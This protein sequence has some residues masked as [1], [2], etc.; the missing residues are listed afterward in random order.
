M[1]PAG[2]PTEERKQCVYECGQNNSEI[3]T[4]LEKNQSEELTFT[5]CSAWGSILGHRLAVFQMSKLP[6]PPPP[7]HHHHHHPSQKSPDP[8]LWGSSSHKS[9]R[10]MGSRGGLTIELYAGIHPYI[11]EMLISRCPYIRT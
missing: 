1:R 8:K 9:R 5:N 10:I 11:R 3:Q 4:S 7:P 2:M 6:P